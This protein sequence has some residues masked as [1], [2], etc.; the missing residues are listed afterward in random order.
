MM[1]LVK[2]ENDDIIRQIRKVKKNNCEI[3]EIG[4]IK[5]PKKN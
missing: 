1:I 5:I 4:H 3:V 2:I